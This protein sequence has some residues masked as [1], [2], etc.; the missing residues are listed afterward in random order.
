[1]SVSPLTQYP[2]QSFRPPRAV[3]ISNQW[4]AVLGALAFVACTSTAFMGCR[5]TQAVVDFFWKAFLG[6][7]HYEK[8]GLVN[9]LCRKYG[10]FFGYGLISLV[11]RNAWYKTARAYAWVTRNWL[12]LFAGTMAV[13]SAFAISGLDE[14]HQH[15]IPGRVGCFSDALVDTAGALFVNVAFWSIRARRRRQAIPV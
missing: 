4:L 12:T 1:M 3:N 10:H 8:A 5:T 7:A 15:F 13:L 6:T 11:F 9:A 2:P 14:L